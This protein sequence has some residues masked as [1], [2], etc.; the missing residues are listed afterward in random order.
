[1]FSKDF[2]KEILIGRK[3]DSVFYL[4]NSNKNKTYKQFINIIKTAVILLAVLLVTSCGG[5]G[6][7][8]GMVAFAPSEDGSIKMHNGGDA[9]GWGKGNETGGG[10]N[11]QLGNINQYEEDSLFNIFPYFFS[12]IQ[13]VDLSLNWNGKPVEGLTGLT[14][15]TKKEILPEFKIGDKISGTARITLADNSVREAVL[16]TTEVNINTKLVFHTDFIYRIEGTTG[17]ASPEGVFRTTT[18]IDVSN[19]ISGALYGYGD[20]TV[21]AFTDGKDTY[22]VTGGW[23]YSPT[24]GDK[25]LTP[26]FKC[27]PEISF[28]GTGVTAVSGSEDT[29]IY[30]YSVNQSGVGI[31][32][33]PSSL[34]GSRVEGSIDGT[35]FELNYGDNPYNVNLLPGEHTLTMNVSGSSD[36]APQTI[37]KTITVYVK[38]DWNLQGASTIADSDIC[39][40]DSSAALDK[41]VYKYA[42]YGD[43]MPFVMESPA[44]TALP[45]YVT[46][47]SYLDGTEITSS[48]TVQRGSH[49]LRVEFSGTYCTFEPVIKTVEVYAKATF[50]E[51]YTATISGTTYKYSY[52]SYGSTGM[53]VVF[54][55]EYPAGASHNIGMKVTINGSATTKTNG[56]AYSGNI[57]LGSNIPIKIEP[58]GSWWDSS[59]VVNKTITVKIKPVTLTPVKVEVCMHRGEDDSDNGLAGKLILGITIIG[60]YNG[61]VISSDHTWTD[62]TNYNSGASTTTLTPVTYQDL[63]DSVEYKAVDMKEWDSGSSDSLGSGTTSKTLLDII[64][65]KNDA[66]EYTIEVTTTG[67]T[68]GSFESK[69]TVKLSD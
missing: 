40:S 4:L 66:K 29:Y 54:T 52:L 57:A 16:D 15:A 19:Y 67:G 10:Y 69:L 1:M 34:S 26:V 6:G 51:Q 2:S 44:Q 33:Q 63:T 28:N 3:T 13:T 37:T 27:E 12:P 39:L 55:P 60:N 42:L 30:D 32:I 38:P 49:T 68:K 22:P 36:C 17:T 46:M 35:S 21:S 5:G 59:S 18:G 48:T 25:V 14:A 9:G 45:S 31:T 23:I 8:G 7:G 56:A 20:S 24:P 53:P 41:Y 61:G 62:A 58:V 47:K 50:N 11:G 65:G 64:N 43:D